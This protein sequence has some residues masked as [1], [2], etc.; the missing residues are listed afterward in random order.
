MAQ[1]TSS[2]IEVLIIDD[3]PILRRGLTL[4]INQEEDLNVCGEAED[5]QSAMD[6]IEQTHPDI[7]LVDISLKDINGI[8][9]VKQILKRWPRLP[10]LVLSRH[11]ESIYAERAIRAGAKGYIMKQESSE[12]FMNAIRKVIQGDIYLSD[13]IEKNIL[14]KQTNTGHSESA[15]QL[16]VLSDRELKVFQ[17]IGKGLQPRQIADRLCISVKTVETY[18]S[19]IRIKLNFVS[20]TDLIQFAIQWIQSENKD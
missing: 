17:L 7:A 12:V 8:D 10:I 14:K 11:P 19:N 2:P 20:A 1:F 18:R 6:A 13:E 5:S 9:L 3:H 4:I 16:N 15:S